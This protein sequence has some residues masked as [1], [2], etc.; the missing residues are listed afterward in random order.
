MDAGR[1]ISYMALEVGTPVLSSSGTQFG[2]VEHV[3]QIPSE[4][5]FDGIVVKMD[6]HGVRFVDR[7]QIGDI[8]TA[9]VTCTISDEEVDSLPEPRGTLELH[10][11]VARDEGPS[12]TARWGRLF[13]R[14]H[15][16]ELE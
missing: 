7:D 14:T 2:T 8:T 6:H 10:P 3:L 9:A 12:L 13:G 5:L 16:K 1:P 11:D 15:W 4:D